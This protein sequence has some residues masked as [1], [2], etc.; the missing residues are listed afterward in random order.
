LIVISPYYRNGAENGTPESHANNYGNTIRFSGPSDG[1]QPS[2]NKNHPHKN[3]RKPGKNG[4]QSKG[5]ER[6]NDVQ[7]GLDSQLEKEMTYLV[8]TEATDL[9]EN[10]DE[11][12]SEAVHEEVPKEEAAMKNFGALKERYMDRYLAVRH[13]GKPKEQTMMGPGRS[14]PPPPAEG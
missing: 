2:R 11:I 3:G 8:K 9:E 6:T 12:E 4:C 7:N 10:S 14:S 5:S 1:C 13:S